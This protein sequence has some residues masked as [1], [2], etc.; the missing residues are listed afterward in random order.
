[1]NGSQF[2]ITLGPAEWLDQT[3]VAFGRVISGM[4]IVREIESVETKKERPVVS[5]I[6]QD[7]G[8]LDNLQ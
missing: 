1:M 4:D 7:C 5:C 2:F 3:K 6:I 8:E